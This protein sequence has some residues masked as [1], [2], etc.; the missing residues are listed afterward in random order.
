[1]KKS[2]KYSVYNLLLMIALSLSSCQEEFEQLPPPDEQQTITASSSTAEL[3]RKTSSHDGSYDNIV[4]GASCIAV[5]FPYKVN[6]NGIEI[7]IDSREDLD[8][9]EEI[10][11]E[12]D[13]PSWEA[14]ADLLDILFPVTITL[15]DFTEIAIKNK[16]ELRALVE[17]CH[18]GDDDDDIECI[19]FV[20]PITLYTF[21]LNEQQTG[22]AVVESDMDLRL[23]FKDLGENDLISIDFPLSLKL[24]NGTEVQVNS[25]AELANA[26]ETAKDSCDEDD[27]NDHNDDD[28]TKERLDEYLVECPWL[29]LDVERDG[30]LQTE[31]YFEYVMD[32][33]ENGEVSVKDRLG[34]SLAGTWSTRVA[35]NKVLLKLEFDVLV[36]FNLEWYVYELE[37]GK[38]KFF[39]EGGNRIILQ[40]ACDLLNTSPDTL[41]EILNEC[42]WVIAKVK[43]QG[44]EIRR[45][46]GY[47]FNFMAEGVVTL[48][49]GGSTAINGTWEITTNTEGRL[50]LAIDMASDPALSF[51]WPLTDLRDDR[52]K[53]AIDDIGYE[54]VLQKVCDDSAGDNDV[55][56]IRNIMMAGD[57]V[58]AR[59]EEGG[60]LETT[61]FAGFSFAFGAE[62]LL[63]ITT[64][65]Q[66]T[67]ATGAWRVLRDSEGKLKVYLNAGDIDPLG[68]LTDDWDFVSVTESRLEVKDLSGDGTLTILVFEKV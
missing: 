15:S 43:N 27:D 2:F 1:M 66:L 10:F 18:K 12:L 13:V 36:D 26:I 19:D 50:V 60:M 5:Q 8:Q 38:I 57:W 58:V 17:E 25:N 48:G 31:Q 35:D 14:G 53:F 33:T 51:E 20:Y 61:D 16:G 64:A 47:E 49:Y 37:E 28:F 4:D 46:I 22:S 65:G 42:S 40:R 24:Y 23:F 67:A 68:E 44:E 41:R 7:S 45:L 63:N 52:L 9:I 56:E 34:N 62:H 11:D 39:S 29:V 54:L 6:V 59:Y 21:D 55:V 30:I 3:I 32:F